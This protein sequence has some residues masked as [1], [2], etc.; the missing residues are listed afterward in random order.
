MIPR[1]NSASVSV[2]F[3]DLIFALQRSGGASVY[4]REVTTRVAKDARLRVVRQPPARWKRGLPAFSSAD[5]FHSSH[6][7]VC[8]AGG[9]RNIATVHDLNYERG[10]VP[11]SIGSRVNVLERKVSYATAAALICISENTRKD[12]L[13]VYPKL[14][15]RCPVFVI[16][17]GVSLPTNDPPPASAP[18][19]PFVLFVG[20]RKSYKNFRT[21]LE[22]F[23]ASG[24][25]RDGTRLL[26]TGTPFDDDEQRRIARMGLSGLVAVVEYCTPERLGALYRAAHCLLYT[27][28]YEGFG[29]PTLEAMISG[30][31]VVAAQAS[32]IPEIAGDAAILVSPTSRDEVARGILALQD[33]GI[34]SRLVAKG[35]QRAALFSWDESA[36]KHAEVYVAVARRTA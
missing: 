20:G 24:V 26:C 9:A 8:L 34:R 14:R 10:L 3:D 33:G 2:E 27:S 35:R 15:G 19:F 17:H 13:E 28:T 30:C 6:F 5:V 36:R 1:P 29:L 32:A 25:W 31:P 23:F 22:G 21:A 7:R 4:W 11:D 18:D 16:H 12:L